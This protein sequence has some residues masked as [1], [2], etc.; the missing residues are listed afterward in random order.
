MYCSNCGNQMPDGSR[1]CR[2]CGASQVP[3]PAP[4]EPQE[5]QPPTQAQFTPSPPPP[6]GYYP[7]QETAP[8][9]PT[10]GSS[11]TIWI[12]LACVGV[13]VVALAVALPLIFLRG[14]GGETDDTTVV[15][16]TTLSESS[17]S[18]PTT[19]TTEQAT[20]TTEAPTTTTAAPAASV[21]GDSAGR[22]AE[23]NVSGLEQSV[24]EVAVSDDALVFESDGT[25][26][27]GIYAYLFDSAQTV[28]LPAAADTIGAVDVHGTIAV[29]WEANGADVITDAHIYA[30]RLPDGPKVEVASGTSVGY[31][32]VVGG[33]ITWVE[34]KPWAAEPDAWW[35]Y[36]IKGASIDTAG[37]PTGAAFT[38]VDYGSALAATL[39]DS[40]WTYSLSEG[41][42]AWEQQ[43]DGDIRGGQ[44]RHGPGRDG[45]LA[46]RQRRLAAVPQQEPGGVHP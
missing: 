41:F 5:Y 43:T 19:E 23:L 3:A 36:T 33:L 39:G 9:P 6:P 37:Q 20:D 34:G 8:R 45:A 46:R 27:I 7:T 13:L 31:P 28:Q 42:L 12:V 32:Q 25:T 4:Q 10:G 35:D 24:T 29:W 11:K 38:I 30:M 40:T 2:E 21:P 26:G 1:F 14:G 17:T 44:L 22:W 15:S 16:T 18:E